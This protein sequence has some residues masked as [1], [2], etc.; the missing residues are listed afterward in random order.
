[1]SQVRRNHELIFDMVQ[2]LLCAAQLGHRGGIGEVEL[3]WRNLIDL[4]SIQRH[5]LPNYYF[6]LL[7][8]DC[9]GRKECFGRL[10]TLRKGHK[11]VE[12]RNSCHL[13]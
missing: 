13:R 11:K 10:R 3:E 12:N 2:G 1:M 6:R 8:M 4:E 5:L 7:S 9:R